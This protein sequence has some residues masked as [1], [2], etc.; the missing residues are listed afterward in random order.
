MGKRMSSKVIAGLA[1]MVEITDVG[2]AW[3]R[4]HRSPKR[5]YANL[6]AARSYAQDLVRRYNARVEKR[7]SR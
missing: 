3:H 7:A 5:V 1:E 2:I 4:A 6:L